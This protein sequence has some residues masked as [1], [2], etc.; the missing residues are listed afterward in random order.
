LFN[1]VFLLN[2]KV[3]KTLF[4]ASLKYLLIISYYLKMVTRIA[5]DRK[6]DKSLNIVDC[7]NLLK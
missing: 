5:K 2:K 1:L 6:K 3:T 7:K 4:K